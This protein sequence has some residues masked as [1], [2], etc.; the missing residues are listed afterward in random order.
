[1]SWIV[2]E[3]LYT[4]RMEIHYPTLRFHTERD[5]FVVWVRWVSMEDPP[6]PEQPP[7]QGIRVELMLNRNSVLA[8]TILYR[9]DLQQPVYL[10]SNRAR[11]MQVLRAATE[12]GLL[13]IQLVIHGSIANAPYVA[14]FL[15]RDYEGESI[16]SRPIETTPL[17]QLQPSVPGDRWQVAGQANLRVHIELV[18]GHL[19]ILH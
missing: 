10:R 17:L 13:D 8:P 16:D 18:G 19:T 11:T 5:S 1:M 6:S 15:A 7:S 14:L 9:K 4:E 2:A 3:R 12:R